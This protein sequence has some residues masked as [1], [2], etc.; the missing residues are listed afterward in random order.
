MDLDPPLSTLYLD[1]VSHSVLLVNAALSSSFIDLTKVL[2]TTT[3]LP[4]YGSIASC[5]A[6]L[7][8]TPNGSLALFGR[9]SFWEV[10]IFPDA[11]LQFKSK[12]VTRNVW[13]HVSI[14]VADDARLLLLLQ[15]SNL[16]L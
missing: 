3:N 6:N 16:L 8:S 14:V 5:L 7:T 2:S 13:R 12:G 15:R 9:V 10:D 1:V 11:V 4:S